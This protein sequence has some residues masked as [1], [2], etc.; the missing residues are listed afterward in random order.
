MEYWQGI[1][2]NQLSRNSKMA[3]KYSNRK[4]KKHVL[5]LKEKQQVNS[6]F[7]SSMKEVREWN[8]LQMLQLYISCRNTTTY[9]QKKCVII[10]I[11]ICFI[12][13]KTL[14][15]ERKWK[16]AFHSR[17]HT[18][19]TQLLSHRKLKSRLHIGHPEH[20]HQQER[21][22]DICSEILPHL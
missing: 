21:L 18:S 10:Q 2:I 6:T 22:F 15:A 11:W 20:I 12:T 1:S 16:F 5:C 13:P 3:P 4:G 7:V 19:L 17:K 9:K 14:R 8:K